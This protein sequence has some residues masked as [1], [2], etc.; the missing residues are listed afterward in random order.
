MHRILQMTRD[1]CFVHLCQVTNELQHMKTNQAYFEPLIG[2]YFDDSWVSMS[3]FLYTTVTVY[4]ITAKLA[5]IRDP[6]VGQKYA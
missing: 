4:H 3:L 5:L 2:D 1:T 6:G